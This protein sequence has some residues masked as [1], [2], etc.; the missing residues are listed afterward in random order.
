MNWPLDSYISNASYL[1]QLNQKLY[2]K[3]VLGINVK[4]VISLWSIDK[5][6]NNNKGV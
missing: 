2:W 1:K 3:N 4:S 5:E 6:Q